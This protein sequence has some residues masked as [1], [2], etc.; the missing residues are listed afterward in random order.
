MMKNFVL[1]V[2]GNV[3]GQA[4]FFLA[5]IKL[6][7]V[8]GPAQF[9]L[10]N[11]AQAWI[12]YFFRLNELGLET[13]GVRE[14]AQ[15]PDQA[16]EW[17]G[18]IVLTRLALSFVLYCLLG[19]C[20][21]CG[22]IP[23]KAI[24]LVLIFSLSLIPLSLSADWIFEAFQNVK[25]VSVAYL[26]RGAIFFFLIFFFVQT[27]HDILDSALFYVISVFISYFA[28]FLLAIKIY[29]I[30]FRGYSITQGIATLRQSFPLGLGTLLSQYSW[31]AG[32]IFIGYIATD[33]T[34]LGYYSAGHRIVI[35]VWGYLCASLY[36]I[37]IPTMTQKYKQDQNS[38]SIFAHQLIKLIATLSITGTL[39]LFILA[40]PL[41]LMLFTAAYSSSI[42]VFQLL[43]WAF[44]LAV[45]RSILE[46]AFISS[47]NANLFLRG[48]LS[49][50]V[51]YTI[52][53][54]ILYILY[55]IKGVAIASVIS[56]FT[57]FM[58]DIWIA[59]FF[60]K[61]KILTTF[62]TPFLC[63]VFAITIY[64]LC[65]NFSFVLQTS[66]TILAFTLPIITFGGVRK[67]DLI[68]ASEFFK[69][70]D[71]PEPRTPS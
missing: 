63:F 13:L 24:S 34:D 11:F 10:W 71:I 41:L 27:Q 20:I 54:P 33:A 51:C 7:R 45:T 48:M 21:L 59:P 32:T 43:L 67:R 50:A 16:K 38:F 15:K 58:F 30:N 22:F 44:V 26:F 64:F 53:T 55:G 6:A 46:V 1:L 12:L 3:G 19:I 18:K 49:I 66:L 2:S 68:L 56:E 8:L 5:L 35:F 69:K 9:G 23:R 25:Q 4:F 40:P 70:R 61:R 36:R 31:F 52:F 39:V 57:G 37:L 42:L 60:D 47:D 65:S 14:S 62:L 17:I 29:G 28:I